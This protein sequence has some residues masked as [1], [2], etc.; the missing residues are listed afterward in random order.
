MGAQPLYRREDRVV[1]RRGVLTA[2]LPHRTLSTS[3]KKTNP[4][5]C[6]ER[7]VVTVQLSNN[8]ITNILTFG[9]TNQRLMKQLTEGS[10]GGSVS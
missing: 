3:V 5:R 8:F 9:G 1:G 4:K 2:A 6:F 10:L 7:G